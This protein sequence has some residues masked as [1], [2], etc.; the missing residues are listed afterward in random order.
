MYACVKLVLKRWLF[1]IEKPVNRQVLT[2]W[3]TDV[4]HIV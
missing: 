1:Q 2:M 4:G 3:H